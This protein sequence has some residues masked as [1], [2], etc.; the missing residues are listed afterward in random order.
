MNTEKRNFLNR[1]PLKNELF[2]SF[3]FAFVFFVA[4]IL[5]IVSLTYS[6]SVEKTYLKQVVSTSQQALSNYSNYMD[7]VI[8]ASDAIQKRLVNET[9]ETIQSQ[10][11]NFFDEIMV[12]L[13]SVNSI[14]LYDDE[15]KLIASDKGYRSDMTKEQVQKE[16][17]FT[18]SLNSPLI[19]H[20]SKVSSSSL[21]TLSKF[22]TIDNGKESAILKIVYDFSGIESVIDETQLGDGGNIYIFDNDYQEV[23]SSLEIPET[24]KTA[25]QETIL[26]QVEIKD[27]ANHIYLYIS[28][29]PKTRWRLA[30]A[31]NINEI[32]KAKSRLFI[33]SF[34]FSAFA[35]LAFLFLFYAVSGQISKPIVRLQ[36]EMES[37]NDLDFQPLESS[38]IGGTKEIVSLNRSYLKMMK[39]IRELAQEVVNEQKEQNKA[40]LKALQNQINPHF[41]YNTLDSIIYLIDEKENEKAQ[42]MIVALS[43]FFRISISRGKNIIP[44]KSELEH[45]RYYLQIQKMRFGEGFDYWIDAS[46]E[47]LSLPVI[48]LILQPIVENAIVHGLGEKPLP[49]AY[50]HIKGYMK[51]EYLVFEVEDNGYGMLPEKIEEIRKSFQDKTIHNGVGLS[52]VYQRI[53]IY[54]GEKADIQVKSSLDCGTDILVL[55]P[56]KEIRNDEE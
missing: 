52:N 13:P 35:L 46:D 29:I 33:N 42:N 5:A 12:V 47:I 17:W 34:L 19:N 26:G 21:F 40:E 37:I 53:R 6:V 31:T 18:L 54:Y 11:R 44:I 2:F 3:L 50:I 45:V 28:T 15:G 24:E 4:G 39:K 23:Y 14:S 25:I 32:A 22:M 9:N 41:L 49:D 7:N 8:I 43:R 30:I 16:E 51:D 56:R 36:K 27:G 55:I 48:K 1:L 10:S 20:F 38:S